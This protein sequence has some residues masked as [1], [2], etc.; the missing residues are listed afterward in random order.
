[1]GLGVQGFGFKVW[2]KGF[3]GF[4]FKGGLGVWVTLGLSWFWL[5]AAFRSIS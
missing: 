5:M 4:G 1:M 3:G 2:G